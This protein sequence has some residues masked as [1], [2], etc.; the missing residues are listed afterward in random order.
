MPRTPRD[1]TSSGRG[2]RRRSATMTGSGPII[3]QVNQI[4]KAN[5][6]LRHENA[7]LLALNEQLRAQLDQIGTALGR[8]TRG[9]R[10]GRGRR[11][12]A[13]SAG[14]PT[15]RRPRRPITDPEVL[16][17]RRQALARARAVRAERRAAAQAGDGSPAEDRG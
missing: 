12:A 16:E 15:A 17:R 6:L 1:T 13:A 9:E 14:E 5:E 11:A 4:V 7:E 2:R 10:R 3:G 8:L